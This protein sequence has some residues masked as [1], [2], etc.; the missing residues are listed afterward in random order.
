[1]WSLK[2]EAAPYL[3]IKSIGTLILISLRNCETCLLCKTPRLRYFCDSSL[4]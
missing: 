2:Q 4:N 1:M 3:D